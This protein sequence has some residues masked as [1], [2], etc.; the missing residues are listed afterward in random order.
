MAV[1]LKGLLL[2][3]EI[4]RAAT[5]IGDQSISASVTRGSVFQGAATHIGDQ[6]VWCLGFLC[7]AFS[8][9]DCLLMSSVLCVA[10]MAFCVDTLSTGDQGL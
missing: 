2:I 7:M 6:C 5:H 10:F 3:S 4:S 8:V 1:S 9:A